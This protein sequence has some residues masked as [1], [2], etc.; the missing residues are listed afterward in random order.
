MLSSLNRWIAVACVGL[1]VCVG[2]FGV[3]IGGF[4][5][6]NDGMVAGLR[7]LGMTAAFSLAL[8]AMSV[9]FRFAA[10]AHA[11]RDPRRWWIQVAAIL[12]AYLAFG[13]AATATSWMDR[14]AG[15]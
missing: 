2:A 12:A 1:A 7:L 3:Y 11:Q 9:A 10:N 8:M 15:H 6:L 4:A 13:L 14:M 5:W